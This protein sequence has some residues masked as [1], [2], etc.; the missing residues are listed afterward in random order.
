MNQVTDGL[1]E[2]VAWHRPLL[3]RTDHAVAQLVFVEGLAAAVVLDQPGHDQFCGFER[4]ESFIA[5]KALPA[6][7]NL[8][9]FTRK[10]RVDDLGFIMGAER[11]V[12]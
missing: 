3:E 6:P 12:H 1:F 7:T 9:A 5:C 10:A 2:F 11:T 4:R 8:P